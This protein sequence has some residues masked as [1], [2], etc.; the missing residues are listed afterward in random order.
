MAMAGASDAP[1]RPLPAP[2]SLLSQAIA[3]LAPFP[4]RAAL[5]WRIALLCAL[6]SA[7]AMLFQT[8]EAA[9]SCYL[10]IFLMKPDAVQ[11]I[12]TAIG[13]IVL[14]ALVVLALIPIINATVETPLLRLLAIALVSFIFLFIGAASQLGEIGGGI[15]SG[16][17]SPLP[18]VVRW[19][20]TRARALRLP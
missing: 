3:D 15:G 5:T 14:V 1:N 10:I 17:S 9:I 2:R 7:T 11:N 19:P 12:G 18:L 8:P 6:V 16:V 13:L 4:G 20:V